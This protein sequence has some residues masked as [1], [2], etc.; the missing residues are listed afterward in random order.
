[1]RNSEAECTNQ[2]GFICCGIVL[3]TAL[4]DFQVPLWCAIAPNITCTR[5]SLDLAV[6]FSPAFGQVTD[7]AART[8]SFMLF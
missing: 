1:M 4:R 6:S 3:H 7:V 2:N 8:C 5:S